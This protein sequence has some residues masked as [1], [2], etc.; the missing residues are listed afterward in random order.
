MSELAH[1]E[2]ASGDTHPFDDIVDMSC[3]LSS[4]GDRTV[5]IKLPR[6]HRL[7][8]CDATM[9]TLLRCK[10]NERRVPAVPASVIGK[11]RIFVVDTGASKDVMS[12]DVAVEFFKEAI[13]PT[14]EKLRFTTASKY[15]YISSGMRIRIAEWD[16]LSDCVLMDNAPKPHDCRSED[17][18]RW[19]VVHLGSA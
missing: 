3:V 17:H 11:H 16:V 14:S 10:D 18:A 1:I 12:T 8:P 13:R 6:P 9:P 5:A 4:D 19:H 15:D 7:Q 2:E